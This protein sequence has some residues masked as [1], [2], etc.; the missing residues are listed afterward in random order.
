MKLAITSNGS[1]L[2]SQFAEDFARCRFFL[3]CDTESGELLDAID[4]PNREASCD[5]SA[6]AARLIVV[7]EADA[8]VTGLIGSEAGEILAATGLETY[9]GIAGTVGKNLRKFRE[10]DLALRKG[11]V[12]GMYSGKGSPATASP[13]EP[14][15]GIGA[16]PGQPT[17][18][19]IGQAEE[20]VCIACGN[21]KPHS[22]GT[23]P[24]DRKCPACSETMILGNKELG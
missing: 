22:P 7:N 1:I 12:T 4:N 8:L 20:W 16:G 23:P 21:R 17:G 19:Q 10:G 3:F 15:E 14:G 9:D 24:A 2:S 11:P 5:E 18:F 13:P 6:E